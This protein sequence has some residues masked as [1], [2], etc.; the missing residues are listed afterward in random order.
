MIKLPDIIRYFLDDENQVCQLKKLSFTINDYELISNNPLIIKRNNKE[1][2]FTSNIIDINISNYDYALLTTNDISLKQLE[3]NPSL[4]KRWIRHPLLNKTEKPDVIAKSWQNKFIFNKEI[5]NINQKGLRSPQ[6]GALHAMVAHLEESEQR[7]VIVMP[8]GTGKTE[9]MLSFLIA[10][11]CKKIMVVVPSDALRMQISNKFITLGLLPELGLIK[12]TFSYPIVA[13]IKNGSIL[14]E[15]WNEIIYASN[16]IVTTMQIASKISDSVMQTLKKEMSYIFIDEAHHSQ[17]STWK[18]FIDKF[19]SSK[20]FLFTATPFRNDGKKIQGDFIFNFSLRKAQEQG[21]YQSINYIPVREYTQENS[22]IEIAKT[23]VNKLKKDIDNGYNHILMARCKSITRANEIFK[24]YNEYKEFNPIIVYSSIKNKK[25]IIE[26]IKAGKHKII[27]CVNMLGEGFDL[28]ELKIAAIHD[29]R[30]SLPITLQ[31]IGRFTRVS[32]EKI[33]KASFITNVANPHI[34]QELND[35]YKQDADWNI[36]LPKISDKATEKE[37]KFSEFISNFKGDLS[38]K[39]SIQDIRPALST[40]IYTTKSTTTSFNNWEK[41]IDGID[42][43]EFKYST[44]SLNTLVIILGK[45]NK[46]PWGDIQNIKNIIWE[47]IIVYFDSY[48]RRIFLNSSFGLNDKKFLSSIFEGQLYKI[49]GD[50]V[51]RVYWNVK[52]LTLFNVGAR[53]HQSG[54][55]SFLSYHGSCVQDGIDEITQ[56]TL[57]KNNLFGIG[58]KNGN[59]ISIGCSVSGKIWSYMRGSLQEFQDWCQNVGDLVQD[60]KIDSNIVLK[61]TLRYH[62]ISRFPTSYPI[63]IDWHPLIY[64]AFET[65]N[66][67]IN[68]KYYNLWDIDLNIDNRTD[69]GKNIRFNIQQGSNIINVIITIYERDNSYI[70]EYY[71]DSTSVIYFYKGQNQYTIKDFFDKYPPVIL[72][73]NGGQ[74]IKNNYCELK[75]KPAMMPD[76]CI[77]KHEWKDVNLSHESQKCIPYI[78]DSIQYHFSNFLKPTYDFLIDDDGS[79]E[80]A[81]LIGISN[82]HETI[83]IGLYHLKFA[84]GGKVSNDINNIYQ[85]C[86]QAQKSIRWKNMQGD[87]FFNHILSRNDKRIKAE[88]SSR[89]LK[90]REEDIIKLKEEAS[91]SKEMKFHIYIVQ[92]G[93][94]KKDA[95]DEIKLLLGNT[96]Q[97]LSNVANIDLHV[98]CSE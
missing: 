5:K 11:A 48:K 95:T 40:L 87:K 35:L 14:D 19:T 82:S 76:Q 81:D 53:H 79:G 89:I 83:D 2:Y 8:T 78:K 47:I 10:N 58:Y 55:I 75:E 67:N 12:S 96:Y 65:F 93:I 90:G 62:L 92:P 32:N 97:Y 80:I 15:Q 7:G 45:A 30:Q 74:I 34:A 86:G 13:A 68:D 28:P 57:I 51:F 24:Y 22:D 36:L 44:K 70:C 6:F 91:Y 49:C 84:I 56:E 88:Q 31:F 42:N 98:Y 71:Y 21:Y 69:V 66:V 27:V 85:V 72:L 94:S 3:E 20:V 73:A 33:G 4:T 77:I 29:E 37:R 63:G 9:T 1:I 23:A 43:Y 54:D 18:N 38:E 59:K 52:R 17:A 26:E 64:E 50:N 46:V 25:H 61:N 41:G 16:V 60:N 39:I